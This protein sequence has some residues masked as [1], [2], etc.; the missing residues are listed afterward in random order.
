MPRAADAAVFAS[1]DGL[2]RREAPFDIGAER[3]TPRFGS[4]AAHTPR[5]SEI[6]QA[7]LARIL[8]FLDSRDE[9]KVI[10]LGASSSIE[11]HP[12]GSI[13]SKS[14]LD[15][16]PRQPKSAVQPQNA[17]FVN[18]SSVAQ[19]QTHVTMS[20]RL[21]AGAGRA[22]LTLVEHALCPLD[23]SGS[24]KGLIKHRS[25]FL[26]QDKHRH[27]RTAIAEIVAI[28]GLL[29]NDEFYLWGLLQLTLRQPEPMVDFY[30]TPVYCLSELG[31]VDKATRGGKSYETFRGALSRLAGVTYSS[32]HFYDP[33][34][35][36]H[37]AV[38][39]GFLSYSLP[40]KGSRRAWRIAW[41][42]IFFEFCRA[43]GGGLNFDLETYRKLDFASRRLFL[44]LKKIFWR[45]SQSPA[46]DVRHL[47]V[48][49]LGFA[50]SLDVR[51]LKVKI[52]RS[53][54][55][56]AKAGIVALPDAGA[57]SLFEKRRVGEYSIQFRKGPRCEARDHNP[58]S[59][60]FVSDHLESSPLYEPLRV[61]GLDNIAIE[62]VIKLYKPHQIQEWADITLAALERKG[63]RFFKV[64]PQAYFIDNLTK[65][66]A[67]TRTA[68]DWWLEFR[69]DEERQERGAIRF[70]E[71]V[72]NTQSSSSS[73]SNDNEVTADQAFEAYLSGEGRAAFSELFDRLVQQY[74]TLGQSSNEVKMRAS[75]A[76]RLHIRTRFRAEHPELD[77]CVPQTIG[78]LLKKLK[79][80]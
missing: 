62:R 21:S 27:Q 44:L 55:T 65:A 3:L 20:K 47:G 2:A 11:S 23:A 5:R 15:H 10:I 57:K 25:E 9:N 64:G 48:N 76:A 31:V 58:A 12:V 14:P 54:E 29:P 79:L 69:N 19:S 24:V 8:S 80:R 59:K 49:I 67:G 61:I 1:S 52:A 33:M 45:Q 4:L 71:G 46:F 68:P 66:A 40:P 60:S 26:Y 50:S 70:D 6:C 73:T 28:D 42:P 13:E 51:D 77:A 78:D 7:I 56:L 74:A 30:A 18:A 32:E 36:E 35:G 16:S 75:S 17:D 43:V 34:R 22:Q 38:R 53:A 41:D 72:T 37:R 63:K 39:F